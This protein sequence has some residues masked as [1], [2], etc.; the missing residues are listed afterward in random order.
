MVWGVVMSQYYDS[1]EISK[2]IEQQ[3][4][5]CK[6]ESINNGTS[7]EIELPVVLYFNYQRLKLNIYPVQDGYFISDDGQS[8]VEYS[9]ETKYY[10]DLF[11][12]KDLNNHYEIQLDNNHIYK[13]YHYDYSLISAID[14]FVRFFIFLDKFIQKNDIV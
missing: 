9:L 8:F 6:W 11:M 14:E 5:I 7:F 4:K 1:K 10:Y 2:K 12:E 13:K 3:L